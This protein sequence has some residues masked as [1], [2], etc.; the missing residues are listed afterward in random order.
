MAVETTEGDLGQ[1]DLSKPRVVEVKEG[2]DGKI[3]GVTIEKGGIF[4]KKIEVPADRVEG[5]EQVGDDG[6]DGKKQDK[7]V[8]STNTGEVD[9]LYATGDEALAPGER[10]QPQKA[11][12]QARK[13]E[14]ATQQTNE[15]PNLLQMLGP[16]LLTGLA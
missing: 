10:A 13:K 4:K 7:L 14:E 2:Q 15:R 8:I 16:G 6:G 9:S 1:T 3:E 11:E 12:E 5:V